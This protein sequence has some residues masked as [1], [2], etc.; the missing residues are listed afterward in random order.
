[1]E[2]S[3]HSQSIRA[4]C[5]V[6][7]GTGLEMVGRDTRSGWN[8]WL[9][10]KSLTSLIPTR[11]LT[12][13]SILLSLC[14][15]PPVVGCMLNIPSSFKGLE[16]WNRKLTGFSEKCFQINFSWCLFLKVHTPEIRL[17]KHS[18]PVVSCSVEF[19]WEKKKKVQPWTLNGAQCESGGLQ[20]CRFK[21]S[22]W[23]FLKT[24]HVFCYWPAAW[25][26]EH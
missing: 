12:T 18:V 1:M 10:W 2:G 24:S 15:M 22:C 8:T 16:A 21:S 25:N 4:I 17:G 6:C 14:W 5:G 13:A 7:G 11:K 3:R 9:S 19:V 23:C 26:S 20:R